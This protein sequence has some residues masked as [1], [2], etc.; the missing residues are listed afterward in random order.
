MKVRLYAKLGRHK[1]AINLLI[2]QEKYEEALT[3]ARENKVDHKE[4]DLTDIAHKQ[5]KKVLRAGNCFTEVAKLVE[6]I[7]NFSQ[8]VH[9]LKQAKQYPKATK[10]LIQKKMYRNALRICKAQHLYAEVI[11]MLEGSDTDQKKYSLMLAQAEHYVATKKTEQAR[12]CLTNLLKLKI[13]VPQKARTNLLLAVAFINEQEPNSSQAEKYCTEAYRLYTKVVKSKAGEIEAFNLLNK[14]LEYTVEHG[15]LITSTIASVE[16]ICTLLYKPA[17]TFTVEISDIELFYS[18]E[19]D[20]SKHYFVPQDSSC[21]QTFDGTQTDSDGMLQLDERETLKQI[22]EHYKHYAANWKLSIRNIKKPWETQVKR[23]FSFHE[24]LLQPPY[25]LQGG[26]KK[27]PQ[28]QIKEYLTMCDLVFQFGQL[29][30]FDIDPNVIIEQVYRLLSPFSQ[31][32]LPFK[33]ETYEHLASLSHIKEVIIK[34]V[35]NQIKVIA[36]NFNTPDLNNWLQ[37]WKILHVLGREK[38]KELQISLKKQAKSI[39]IIALTY[40]RNPTQGPPYSY[41]HRNNHDYQSILSLWDQSCELYRHHNKALIATKISFQNFIQTIARRKSLNETFSLENLISILTVQSTALLAMQSASLFKYNQY[42]TMVIPESFESLMNNFDMIYSCSDINGRLLTACLNTSE[43]VSPD[44]VL[45]DTKNILLE[46]FNLLIGEY[47]R[48]YN[49]LKKAL[50]DGTNTEAVHCLALALTILGNLVLHK[51]ISVSTSLHF[52]YAIVKVLEASTKYKEACHALKNCTD[53]KSLFQILQQLLTSIDLKLVSLQTVTSLGKVNLRIKS[54]LFPSQ[55]PIISFSLKPQPDSVQVVGSEA[56]NQSESKTND[57]DQLGKHP[58]DSESEDEDEDEDIHAELNAMENIEYKPEPEPV[59]DTVLEEEKRQCLHNDQCIICNKPVQSNDEHF[60]TEAH[61][62]EKKCYNSCQNIFFVF[63]MT[64]KKLLELIHTCREENVGNDEL[65]KIL[66]E[67]DDLIEKN[68]EEMT[69]VSQGCTWNERRANLS[70]L[71]D[72][73]ENIIGLVCKQQEKLAQKK[74]QQIFAPLS[75][76]E[77]SEED[78]ELN[79]ELKETR[80]KPS[81]KRRK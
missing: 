71:M 68:K 11:D 63:N 24:E 76:E 78:E 53:T 28:N 37:L 13:S 6:F 2:A 54:P 57:K 73:T 16:Q 30:T 26:P 8:K 58:S 20:G 40:R 18:L 50:C 9:F 14:V 32:C 23:S 35:S 12:E 59:V 36:F 60:K 10:L 70:Q 55:I 44:K 7:P 67:A 41:I 80:K 65:E 79:I 3:M 21:F 25:Y 45:Q 52:L 47:R 49:P 33:Q 38:V 5:I 62:E 42:N 22:Q 31:I 43:Q 74:E 34:K 64:Q 19:K 56:S 17:A 81:K 69:Q 15:R 75:D 1:K 39:N 29:T 61:I 77:K 72:K 66:L 48:H 46:I 4:L 27:F 51:W